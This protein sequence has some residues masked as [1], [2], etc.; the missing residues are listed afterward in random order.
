[1]PFLDGFY[2]SSASSHWHIEWASGNSQECDF[3]TPDYD[4]AVDEFRHVCRVFVDPELAVAT[5]ARTYASVVFAYLGY[6]ENRLPVHGSCVSRDGFALCIAGRPGAGKSTLAAALVARGSKF[7]S[8][9]VTIV[10]PDS[11]NVQLGPP[12]RRL[13]DDAL[14][15]LGDDPAKYPPLEQG[16]PKRVC[17]VPE[18]DL[19]VEA[20]LLWKVFVVE[21]GETLALDPLGPQES[22]ME[23]VRH[24]FL[25]PW[26]DVKEAPKVTQLSAALARKVSVYRLRRP[27]RLEALKETVELLEGEFHST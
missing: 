27:K 2:Q 22:V 10:D 9:G 5:A 12:A 6:L 1:M 21:D 13:W 19:V 25:S 23:L 16:P 17:T 14:R 11:M 26:L 20:P 4:I 18:S 7:V 3:S 8:D 15:W 24:G